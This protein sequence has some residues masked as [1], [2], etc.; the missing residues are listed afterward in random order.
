MLINKRVRGRETPWIT[1]KIKN[2]M[3]ERDYF[4]TKAR[5]GKSELDWSKYRNLRNMVTREIRKAKGRYYRN[6]L[7]ENLDNPSKFWKAVKSLYQM[8][9]HLP[10]LAPSELNMMIN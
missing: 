4:L 9:S 5:S 1:S 3:R 10:K 7:E 8:K 6:L 2:S